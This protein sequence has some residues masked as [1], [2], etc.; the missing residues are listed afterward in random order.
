M[1]L[2]TKNNAIIVKD[3][4]LAEDC[5]CCGGWY[6]YPP[7]L[8]CNVCPELPSTISLS[9]S[10]PQISTFYTTVLLNI[11]GVMTWRNLRW[12]PSLTGSTTFTLT[13]DRSFIFGFCSYSYNA[14]P[15]GVGGNGGQIRQQD[16]SLPMFSMAVGYR[17][18]SITSGGA[19]CQSGYVYPF[20]FH[21]MTLVVGGV[22]YATNAQFVPPSNANFV[23]P[24]NDSYGSA[25]TA[26]FHLDG[27]YLP[28]SSVTDGWYA[29]YGEVAS[30]GG[31]QIR[32]ERPFQGGIAVPFFYGTST[33]TAGYG[34]IDLSLQAA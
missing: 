2:A 1:T 10:F 9:I 23:Q 22:S 7:P 33:G 29:I 12:T 19:E 28:T 11:G 3:G 34:Q 14:G 24:E 5:G 17:K 13:K 8:P 27:G 25:T 18:P 4:K 6:C 21:Q 32:L 30:S 16:S 26:S 31:C 20:S 15:L